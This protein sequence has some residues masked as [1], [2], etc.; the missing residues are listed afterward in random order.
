MATY[1]KGLICTPM[2]AE[3]AARLSFPPMVAEDSENRS[4]AFTVAV[5]H[6]DTTT[7]ISAAD[8]SYTIMKCVDDQSKPEDFRRPAHVFPLIS[9]KGGVLVRNGHTEAT[10][11]LM[12]LAGLKECGV[13]CEV[14]KE[15]GTMMRT[16]QLWEMAKEHNLTFITIRD[17]Q[18]YMRIHEKHVKEEETPLADGNAMI[19]SAMKQLGKTRIVTVGHVCNHAYGD[20]ED[21]YQRMS[22]KFMQIFWPGVYKDM[23]KMGQVLARSDL[24]WT[25][26]RTCPGRDGK[27]KKVGQNCSISLDGSQFRPGYSREALAE[28]LY[29]AAADQQMYSRKMPIFYREG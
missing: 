22:T 2:S 5:D 9:R 13:C 26:V 17:L 3:I 18:D 4:T 10:T 16:S 21:K 19:L 1:A 14:M 25:L 11:D 23:Q 15:D 27:V 8:R 24:N 6:V 20:C 29:E 28:F 12:R 7:G